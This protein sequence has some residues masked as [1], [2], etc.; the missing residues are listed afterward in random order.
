MTDY[1]ASSM[2][3]S[4][5]GVFRVGSGVDVEKDAPPAPFIP[6]SLSYDPYSHKATEYKI[7]SCARPH[8]RAFHLA[9]ISFLM[10]F[11]A[12]FSFAPLAPAIKKSLKLTKQQILIANVTSVG[13]TVFARFAIGP[14]MDVIGPRLGQCGILVFAAIP[15][16]FAGLIQNLAGL[17]TVRA[18]VGIVGAAFVGCQFWCSIMFSKEIAGTMNAIAGGWGNL[19]GG[20]TQIIMVGIYEMNRSSSTCDN[21]CAWR[22]A[23]YIPAFALLVAALLVYTLGD[24]CPKGTYVRESNKHA[25]AAAGVVASNPQVWILVVQY[26]VC[27]GVELHV[28]NTAA[29]Y[30]F[31]RFNVSLSTAGLVASLFGLMNLFAR[32]WGGMISDFCYSRYGMPGRK[33]AHIIITCGEGIALVIFSRMA[34]FAGAIIIMILFSLFVQ[35]AEGSTFGIVPYVDPPHT[36]GVCG[37]VGAGGNIGAVL[38]GVLFIFTESFAQGFFILGWIVFGVGLT[39]II[40]NVKDKDASGKAMDSTTGSAVELKASAP[41]KV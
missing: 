15:T 18:L 39:G 27:F 21:E 20:L 19:G 30:Y 25:G 41:V 7:N 4:V 29:L 10:A 22:N 28:N 6:F 26:A 9:W 40:I 5:D 34:T 2:D 32:A 37:F 36:G 1:K 8:M 31:D 11:I 33:Y 13:S 23:F 16:F 3:S 12:W 17:A 35:S 24:D 38:W 14:V